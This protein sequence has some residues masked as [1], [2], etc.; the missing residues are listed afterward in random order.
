MVATGVTAI[1]SLGV[2]IPL[3]F[4]DGLAGLA[5]GIGA[6]ALANLVLRAFYVRRLFRG[7]AFAAHAVRALL[8][9]LPGVVIVIVVRLITP[10][11]DTVGAAIAL[12]AVYLLAVIAGTLL[13][14]RALLSEA[15]AYALRRRG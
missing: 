6:G 7:F 15:L 3:L 8:P 13:F 14:E 10:G 11:A 9:T 4:A 12:L 1:V 2:G 5:I